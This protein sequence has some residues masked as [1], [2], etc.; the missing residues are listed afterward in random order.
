MA[1]KALV[2]LS[3]LACF[4]FPHGRIFGENRTSYAANAKHNLIVRPTAV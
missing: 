2:F 4:A 1:L 3:P